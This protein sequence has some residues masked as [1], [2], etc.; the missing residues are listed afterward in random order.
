M[1]GFLL[2]NLCLVQAN[3]A[4]VS[5]QP[6]LPLEPLPPPLVYRYYHHVA[7]QN[8]K[9]VDQC[10][11]LE[12]HKHIIKSVVYIHTQHFFMYESLTSGSKVLLFCW[13]VSGWSLVE[14]SGW[15]LVWENV[16]KSSC[17]S[18]MWP[19]FKRWWIYSC[20]V[21]SIRFPWTDTWWK[22]I[23]QKYQ[24]IQRQQEGVARGRGSVLSW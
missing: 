2:G 1:F 23:K 15:S 14:S 10:W 22:H 19:S 13:P 20:L 6:A 12:L 9:L 8:W 16:S 4:P 11:I 5:G 3:T 21:L 17:K 24:G 7:P 18:L